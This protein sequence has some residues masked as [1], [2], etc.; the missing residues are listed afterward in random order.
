M[1]PSVDPGVNF[2]GV[3][4]IE[5]CLLNVEQFLVRFEDVHL[6]ANSALVPLEHFFSPSVVD[7]S[8]GQGPLLVFVFA[9]RFLEHMVDDLLDVQRRRH[10]I[11]GQSEGIA[12]LRG[13]LPPLDG[14]QVRMD[15]SRGPEPAF[16]LMMLT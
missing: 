11:D 1:L 8:P 12:L 14:M 2:S 3:S 13:I 15:S 6:F 9:K 4:G 16:A 7:E 10:P 5:H